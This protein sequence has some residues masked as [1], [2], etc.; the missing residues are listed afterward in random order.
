MTGITD[1][2]AVAF[3]LDDTLYAHRQYVTA[4]FEAAAEL[5]HERTGVEIYDDLVT[6][7]YEQELYKRT[8][9]AVLEK[10][11]VSTDLVPQL[12]ERYH[13]EIGDLE[14]FPDTEGVLKDLANNYRLALITDGKNVSEKLEQLGLEEYFE[15]VVAT[16]NREVTKREPAPYEELLSHFDAL[17]ASV[18]YVGDDPRYEFRYPNR[19]GMY[20]VWVRRG[21]HAD[22]TPANDCTPDSEIDTLRELPQVI[23]EWDEN[24]IPDQN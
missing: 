12:V 21:L 18:A 14:P 8:F 19:L 22:R 9:D 7:Y 17:P 11:D 15:F 4:G 13:D 2:P 23:R 10:Y 3:D 24:L 6:A 20:T 16:T 1:T 5:V